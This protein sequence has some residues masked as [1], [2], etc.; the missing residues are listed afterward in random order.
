MSAQETQG[1][2][3]ESVS[4]RFRGSDCA[5]CL[6]LELKGEQGSASP[7]QDPGPPPGIRPT[8]PGGC[9]R[10]ELGNGFHRAGKCV[11]H[12]LLSLLLVRT[13]LEKIAKT[14]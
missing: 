8:P 7:S 2:A 5:R 13:D 9:P 14:L 1:T 4:V 12:K 10:R 11:P 3:L 6:R